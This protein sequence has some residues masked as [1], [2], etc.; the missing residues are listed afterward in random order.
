LS[1]EAA[2]HVPNFDFQPADLLD[3]PCSGTGWLGREWLERREPQCTCGA[4]DP[5]DINVLHEVSCDSVPCPFCP[6]E[7]TSA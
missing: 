4:G 5:T 7:A 1:A 2:S 6:A 3:C